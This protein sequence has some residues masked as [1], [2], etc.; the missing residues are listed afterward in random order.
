MSKAQGGLG[1]RSLYGLNIALIEK[2]CWNIVKNPQPLV[3][4]VP[5]ARYFPATSFLKA[6]V[7]SGSSFIWRGIVTARNTISEGFCW[8]LG[9]GNEIDIFKDP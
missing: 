7:K 9:D 4:R 8:D 3:A 2:L 6:N 1:F 5:K